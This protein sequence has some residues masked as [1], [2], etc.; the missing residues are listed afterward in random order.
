VKPVCQAVGVARFHLIELMT[1]SPDWVDGRTVRRIDVL[2]DLALVD[3]IRAEMAN[4]RRT[5]TD[6]LEH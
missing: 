2:A 6:A 1:R 5:D 4:C 3:A